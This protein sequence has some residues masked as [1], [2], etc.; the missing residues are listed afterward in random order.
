MTALAGRIRRDRGLAYVHEFIEEAKSGGF[1]KRMIETAG[2]R[3]V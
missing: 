2:L 1:G 3:G